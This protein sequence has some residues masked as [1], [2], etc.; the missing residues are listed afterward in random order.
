MSSPLFCAKCGGELK[1]S[2]DG[3]KC[4]NCNKEYPISRGNNQKK[5]FFKEF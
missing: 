3:Y 4:L 5:E 2:N 1:L